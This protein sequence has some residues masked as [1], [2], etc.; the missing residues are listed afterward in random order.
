MSKL[1]DALERYGHHE[2]GCR[3]DISECDCGLS[4]ALLDGAA[5]E[6]RVEL[7]ENA[8]RESEAE[9]KQFRKFQALAKELNEKLRSV[10][11]DDDVLGVALEFLDHY[12]S[13]T[14]EPT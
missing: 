1:L 8:Y 11:R 5:A 6:A 13:L 7:L 4:Q 3:M 10:S 14:K 12:D 2:R 9:V